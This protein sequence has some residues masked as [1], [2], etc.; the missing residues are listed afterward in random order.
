[1]S[2][3]APHECNRDNK[4]FHMDWTITLGNLLTMGA[5]AVA[6]FAYSTTIETR[7]VKQSGDIGNN[8]SSIERVSAD[9]AIDRTEINLTLRDIAKELKEL[10]QRSH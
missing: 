3:D 2:D 6:I 8:T 10:N 4:S 7:F 9:R 1:M 5:L